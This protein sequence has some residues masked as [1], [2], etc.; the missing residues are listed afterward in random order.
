MH[1]I[2]FLFLFSA[3]CATQITIRSE[4]LTV[5]I[6]DTPETRAQG[7]MFREELPEGHGMLFVYPH[8]E[9]QWFWM[10]NTLIPLSL[11]YFN[12]ERTLIQI[13]DM[14]PPKPNKALIRYPSNSGIRYAL[15][16]PQ[17]WFE[18]HGIELGAKFSFLDQA[19]QV[20]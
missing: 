15:E 7:L 18:Q 14:D 12:E 16:V 6:A 11:G 9:R 5:E 4:I 8:T 3:L 10:K 20:K 2:L 19:D 1:R 13:V 17:G